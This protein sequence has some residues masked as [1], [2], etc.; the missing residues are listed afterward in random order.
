[1]TEHDEWLASDLSAGPDAL[2]VPGCCPIE[3]R[4]FIAGPMAIFDPLVE[5]KHQTYHGR[6][7]RGQQTPGRRV[8]ARRGGVERG[9]AGRGEMG[10]CSVDQD[11]GGSVRRGNLRPAC[12]PKN[13][14]ERMS[15]TFS[16][17]RGYKILCKPMEEHNERLTSGRRAAVKRFIR[18]VTAALRSWLLTSGPNLSTFQIVFMQGIAEIVAPRNEYGRGF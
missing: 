11:A 10:W 13:T 17:A 9:G 2:F 4:L 1:M 14:K 16:E 8:G 3:R 12:S 7:G 5:S 6:V 15:W 18:R